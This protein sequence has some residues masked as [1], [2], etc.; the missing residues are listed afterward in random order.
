MKKLIWTRIEGKKEGINERTSKCLNKRTALCSYK[1]IYANFGVAW[2]HS[3]M[4]VVG[5]L[6][7][8]SPTDALSKRPISILPSRS[9]SSTPTLNTRHLKSPQR[10]SLCVR[11]SPNFL[12]Q[13]HARNTAR[14]YPEHQAKNPDHQANGVRFHK[15]TRAFRSII[16]RSS[17]RICMYRV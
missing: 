5:F 17:P 8:A 13:Y 1:N 11:R 4:Q 3:C 7:T 15:L 2:K 12:F 6:H 9:I 14:A 10:C 16:L